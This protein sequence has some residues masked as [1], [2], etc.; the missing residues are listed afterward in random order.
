MSIE[1]CVVY[2]CNA[3]T[4]SDKSNLLITAHSSNVHRIRQQLL[5]S[6]IWSAENEI[7]LSDKSTDDSVMKF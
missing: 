7:T 2:V 5:H 1:L 3:F 4:G 6:C